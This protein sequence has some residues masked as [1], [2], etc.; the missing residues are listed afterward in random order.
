[1][2]CIDSEI[3]R[4]SNRVI[5]YDIE[6][7]IETP[8][9][10]LGRIKTLN[11]HSDPSLERPFSKLNFSNTCVPNHVHCDLQEQVGPQLQST[12][13]HASAR[14]EHPTKEY[15]KK[16][17]LDFLKPQKHH[18]IENLVIHHCV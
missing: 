2:R 7:N 3:E 11:F 10:D 18:N 13:G 1:M 8:G 12:Q 5:A 4:Q 6:S 17:E 15:A 14:T 16:W 9:K